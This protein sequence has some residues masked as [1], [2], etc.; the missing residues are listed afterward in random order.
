MRNLGLAFGLASLT[1]L[2]ACAS[3]DEQG[4]TGSGEPFGQA[5]TT[6]R[7]DAQRVPASEQTSV[8]EACMA[9]AGWRQL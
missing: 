5:E 3:T 1:L 7:Q 2:G 9:R 6:C 4:W 8:F